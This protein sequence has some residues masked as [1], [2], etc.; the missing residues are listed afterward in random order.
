MAIVKEIYPANADL[1]NQYEMNYKTSTSS[2][3]ELIGKYKDEDAKGT[4]NEDS[5][6]NYA[7]T[8]AAPDKQGD[9]DSAQKVDVSLAAADAFGKAYNLNN[10]EG[11]YAYNAGLLNFNVWRDLDDRFFNYAG[12]S[13]EYKAKRAEILKQQQDYFAKASEWLEKAYT[14]LKAKTDRDKKDDNVLN[15]T[16]TMLSNLFQWKRDKSKGNDKDYD[17]YD[18]KFKLYDA[19]VGK[20]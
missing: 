5:Y 4:L 7:Q 11:L 19:E 15:R 20:Y 10:K 13:A 1:W 9:L 3:T 6:V 12:E 14:T 18:A 16:V 17:A 8:F 2:V